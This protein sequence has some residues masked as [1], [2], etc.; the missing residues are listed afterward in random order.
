MG[1]ADEKEAKRM[2]E[3]TT[4][5]EEKGRVKGI[6]EGKAEGQ[7][8]ILLRQLKKKFGYLPVFLIIV[9]FSR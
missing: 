7:V 2:L 3:I 6:A 8:S 1:K 4:S 9:C 5:W